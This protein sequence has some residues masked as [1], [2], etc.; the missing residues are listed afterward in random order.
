[1][2]QENDREFLFRALAR[3][4]CV[5]FTGAG[6]SAEAT[7]QLGRPIPDAWQLANLL[8]DWLGFTGA[9]DSSPLDELYEA[10]MNS[11][12]PMTSLRSFLEEN[13]LATSTESW[14][15]VVPRV[16]WYRI[17]STNVDD[18][19]ESVFRNAGQSSFLRTLAAPIADFEERDQFLR[20][21][22]YIKLNGSLPGNPETL[23]FSP[24]QYARRTSEHDVW[25]D[26]FV[27]DYVYHPVI[28]VGTRL[29]E[30][31]FWQ[32]IV[33]RQKRG[34]NS[35][36]RARSFLVSPSVS[37]AQ[38]P[39]LASL[40]IRHVEASGKDFFMWL[41]ETFT[42]PDRAN[43]LNE[44]VPDAKEIL[45]LTSGV[46]GAQEAVPEFLTAFNRVPIPSRR[47]DHRKTFFLGA[48][49]TWQ[50][51]GN[52]FDAPRECSEFI[53][54]TVESA[55]SKREIGL[56]GLLGAGGSGKSTLLRRLG[57]TLRQAG[58][59]AFLTEGAERPDVSVVRAAL[60]AFQTK[61]VLLLDN[62][63]LMG[64]YL[65][66]LALG[67][68]K[69][70]QPPVIVFAARSNLF[71]RQLQLLQRTPNVKL[72]EVPDLSD[73]D[74]VQLIETL[75][76]NRQLGRLEPMD[77]KHRFEEFKIRARKQILVA[78]REATQGSGFNDIIRSEFSDLETSDPT[79]SEAQSLFLCAALATCEE[80]DLS[81]DQW[82]ACASVSPADA[83]GILRRNLRGL[84]H[85]LSDSRRIAA[86]HPVIAEYIVESVANRS[87][88]VEA[89]KRLLPALA[90]DIYTGVGRRGRSWRLFVRLINH[91][92]IYRRFTENID[93]ARSI[94]DSVS[95]WFR[96]DG[97]YWLQYANLEIEYGEP[98]LAR[99]HLAHAEALMPD[100]EQ[101]LTTQ[102]HLA[103]REAI[104]AK[105]LQEAVELRISAEE[106]LSDQIGR[107]GNEDEY[108]YHVY[109][110]Q[111]L[112][113]VRRW[114]VQMEPERHRQL[115]ED[116]DTLAG[117]AGRKHPSKR[118]KDV[119]EAVRREYLSL[120][121]R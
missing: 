2:L 11:G 64:R 52:D 42:F 70:S 26:H 87:A 94:Y 16:L 82:L 24:R 99:P 43:V 9:Y 59:H 54:D 44:T 95:E 27:R 106:I 38:I 66:D 31:L 25:Y 110:S 19:L 3:N 72:I 80:I 86:R 77:E 73:A 18:V 89:Y 57:V 37:P 108:P 74:I 58:R 98:R 84:L 116:L 20:A 68:S 21:I 100:H 51:I 105:S 39:I 55:W 75:K 71:E 13:L 6:F 81:R 63:P 69:M 56:I 79:N 113:W 90:H 76:V 93:M 103:L 85:E 92:A 50:D 62:A 65:S 53:L 88:V 29:R 112:N 28:F 47:S 107:V 30:P 46:P 17:Y 4:N 109:L 117:D 67:L 12:R 78:M 40:N 61:S 119:T 96:R 36:E 14:Y 83:L 45:D 15:Q 49:P 7:N 114:G 5:L 1:V 101:L 118:I 97:F 41:S 22:Q 35:E 48:P 23:T 33:S 111:G 91:V 121:V 10:A 60:E 104:Q 115:L 34:D 102:A 32:A 8:W 120:A